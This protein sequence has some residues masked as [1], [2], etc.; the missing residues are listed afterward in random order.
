M[1]LF[2]PFARG[3]G[4]QVPAVNDCGKKFRKPRLIRFNGICILFG[5]FALAKQQIKAYDL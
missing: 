2:C 3:S 5:E 1:A 4:G